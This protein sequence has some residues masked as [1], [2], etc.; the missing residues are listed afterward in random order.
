MRINI[1]RFKH[2][3]VLG[4]TS[5][6]CVLNAD[7]LMSEKQNCDELNRIRELPYLKIVHFLENMGKWSI[8]AKPHRSL[9]LNSCNVYFN[10]IVYGV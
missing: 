8:F 5:I 10:I 9:H 6:A 1:I 3:K 7:C 2:H 4:D